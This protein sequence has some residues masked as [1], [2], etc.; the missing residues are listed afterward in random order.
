[1]FTLLK[2]LHD[3]KQ[4]TVLARKQEFNERNLIS[5]SPTSLNNRSPR[6]I[7]HKPL[8]YWLDKSFVK[9]D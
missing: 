9:M 8:S 4:T 3:A 2:W 7:V 1:M 5:R 6:G